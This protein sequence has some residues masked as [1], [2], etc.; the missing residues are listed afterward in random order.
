MNIINLKFN[1]IYICGQS[2][3]GKALLLELL[4]SHKMIKCTPYHN[5]GMSHLYY[6]FVKQLETNKY[7]HKI[8]INKSTNPDKYKRIFENI[9]ELQREKLIKPP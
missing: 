5:F 9:N 1:K 6:E 2:H 7:A 3:S 4:D 8:F